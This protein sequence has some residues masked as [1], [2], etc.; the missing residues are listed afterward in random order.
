MKRIL[1]L[2]LA[3]L[4]IAA[5]TACAPAVNTPAK[6]EAVSEAPAEAP[7]EKMAEESAA[8]PAVE[9]AADAPYVILVNA[10]VG[11]PVYEQQAEGA[12]KAADDYGVNLEII[13]AALGSTD[14]LGETTNFIDSAIAK[15]PDAMITEPWDTTLNAALQRIHDAGIPNFCTSS[16][17]D[18]EENYV[19]YIGTDNKN[20]GIKAADMIAEKTGGKANICVMMANLSAQNQIEMKDGLEQQIA[21]KYPDMKVV[22]TE[23]DNAD[24]PTAV[25]KFQEIFNAYPEVDTVFMVEATGGPAA[26]QV[27]AEM[28]KQVLILDIDAVEQ[29]IDNIKNGT[30]W[31]TLAQ[32]FFKRGYET[33]RMAAE[34]LA[35]GN[36]DSFEKMNDSGVVL[37]TQDNIDTYEED[38]WA[39][40]RMK[41]T[42]MK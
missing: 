7:T 15:Q 24:M 38:L 17:A 31:A 16:P 3:L 19:A 25:S 4:M 39:A 22:V 5:L 8:E 10:I 28:D 1:T 2:V 26:A 23:A 11:H 29:T 13:G 33:V 6:S 32:N 14:L 40:V 21:A 12:R 37:I 9:T 35:N 36:A 42:P 41:G 34:Y 20:Y 27:A 18:K 30:E